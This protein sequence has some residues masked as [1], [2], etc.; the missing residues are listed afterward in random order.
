MKILLQLL[1]HPKALNY[2]NPQKT[3]EKISSKRGSAMTQSMQKTEHLIPALNDKELKR[4]STGNF[5]GLLCISNLG[6]LPQ[7]FQITQVGLYNQ[8]LVV[9][10]NI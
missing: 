8:H 9:M 6:S 4:A 5:S 1:V 7:T 3:V 2:L 10:M